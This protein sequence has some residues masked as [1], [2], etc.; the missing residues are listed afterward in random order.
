M[1]VHIALLKY[2]A[3]KYFAA[4]DLNDE[5]GFGTSGTKRFYKS[6]LTAM[7]FW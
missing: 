7:T 1:D 6:N 4:F 2:V 3:E 5:G